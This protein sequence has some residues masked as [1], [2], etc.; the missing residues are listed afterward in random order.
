VSYLPPDAFSY[1]LTR[2][3]DQRGAFAEMLRTPDAGQ[4]SFFTAPG[5]TTRGGH[6]HHTK[7]E[8]FLVVQGRAR[9][10]FRHLL[11]GERVDLEVEARESRV[12]ETVPGWAH[13]VT[14]IGEGEMVVMLWANEV[15]DPSR[16][17]TVATGLDP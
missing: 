1:A 16:P 17:D 7:T 13:D 10:R 3:E 6:Y 11:T 4:F 9:F 5:G 2:H 15:F 8:K 12:V 14:N